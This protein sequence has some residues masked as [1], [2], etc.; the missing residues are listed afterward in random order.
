MRSASN[1]GIPAVIVAQRL[2]MSAERVRRLVLAGHL[3]GEL[4]AGRWLVNEA[5]VERAVK[6]GFPDGNRLGR[7]P[8]DPR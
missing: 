4:V 2:G 7:R 3:T 8:L 5:S 6:M 1:R